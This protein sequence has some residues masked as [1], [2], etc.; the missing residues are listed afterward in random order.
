[1]IWYSSSTPI[2]S[3]GGCMLSPLFRSLPW[4]DDECW[5]GRPSPCRH[6]EQRRR[7]EAG[8]ATVHVAPFADE[9]ICIHEAVHNAQLA[10]DHAGKWLA[11][12]ADALLYDIRLQPSRPILRCLQRPIPLLGL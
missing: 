7:G 1:M 8:Q 10:V 11:G 3:D 12:D 2:V 9:W 5:H 6:V 4:L